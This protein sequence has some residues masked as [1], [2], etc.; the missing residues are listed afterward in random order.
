V[1]LL[2]V[3][4]T[5]GVNLLG[6][7][8]D[9]RATV[10]VWFRGIFL[11]RPDPSLMVG[12]PL[13][14]SCTCSPRSGCSRSGRSPGWCTSGRCRSE[15]CGSLP[16]SAAIAPPPPPESSPDELVARAMLPGS[17]RSNARSCRGWRGRAVRRWWWRTVEYGCLSRP[18]RTGGLICF[19]WRLPRIWP[20]TRVCP[21]PTPSPVFRWLRSVGG[22]GFS[23]ARSNGM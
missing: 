7:G 13:L 1:V 6:A 3:W 10:A 17:A 4:A 23:V 16:R 19:A 14:F 8:Y 18:R 12:A 9:Y 20:A 2:G 15:C 22:T 11:L 5:V 21:V